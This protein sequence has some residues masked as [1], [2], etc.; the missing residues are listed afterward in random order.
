MPTA[1]KISAKQTFSWVLLAELEMA[2][3]SWGRPLRAGDVRAIAVG[4]DPDKIG[5]I[6]VWSRPELPV[7]R[8]RS[9]IIDGQHRCAALRLIGYD[10]QRVPCLIYEGLTIETAAE[11]SLGLQERRNLHALDKH[12]AA[13][14][15]HERRA[16]DVEKILAY[17]KL[18]LTY[19]TKQGDRRKVSAIATINQI[20]D[21]MGESL[22]R[23]LAVCDDA[24]E[25]TSAGFTTA[26]L[27]L[28]MF[29]L[30][31]HNGEVDDEHLAATLGIRSPAQWVMKDITPRRPLASIAQ[32][33]IIEYNKKARG[34]NRLQE[35]TPSEYQA[36]AKRPPSATVRGAIVGRQTA[37][38]GVRRTRTGQERKEPSNAI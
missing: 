25:G 30:A 18:T 12:R 27:K 33:V 38:V 21:S 29:V 36:A 26:V 6:A 34:G 8:G 11:L 15:A 3:S 14:A 7:G 17:R 9:V 13:L 19:N 24:W 1:P 23:V 31:A 2:P 22:E 35:L 4:F 28:V 32:D 10:D 20:W 5:A 37:G 16:T